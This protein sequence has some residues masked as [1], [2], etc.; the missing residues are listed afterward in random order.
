MST[1]KVAY[2]EP[3]KLHIV[4]I[5][6]E[7]NGEGEDVD[8][9]FDERIAL[10]LDENFVKNI[11]VY[12]INTPVLCRS[13]A[14]RNV[15]VDGR[16]RVR[17]ARE[18]NKRF[19]E[20]GEI[21]LKVPVVLVNGSD[22]R[23]QGIMISANEQR[24]DDTVLTKARKAARMIAM[25]GNKEEVA[26]AFG[27]TTVTIN[28][29]LRL[30]NAVTTIHEAIEAGLISATAGVE[31][32]ALPR[33]EQVAALTEL[34]KAQKG[35]SSNPSSKPV[36]A[37][38]AKAAKSGRG[39]QEGVKRSW[40]KKVIQTETFKT[41]K[42]QQRAVLTWFATGHCD[43]DSWMDEFMWNA[44]NEIEDQI[45][46]KQKARLAKKAKPAPVAAPEEE[47]EDDSTSLSFEAVEEA[48]VVES[49]EAELPTSDVDS[50]GM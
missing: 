48:A 49:P 40:V 15:V 20:A 29:W 39:Q 9:L 25:T 11:M 45:A 35:S 36:S 33:D 2:I 50:M 12:G 47:A 28:S 13:E 19:N 10:E 14:G 1:T 30:I 44:Q 42:P 38:A 6:D 24:R 7:Q 26:I 37:K 18:A 34:L 32:S 27:K 31:L 3:S 5:D 23:V 16:Q 17:A 4:G 22:K 21:P 43:Q 41:L 46:A 8:A